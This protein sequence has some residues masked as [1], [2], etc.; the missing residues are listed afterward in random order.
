MLSTLTILQVMVLSIVFATAP[1][2]GAVIEMISYG[3]ISMVDAV[4]KSGDS[5]N[6]TLLVKDII[7]VA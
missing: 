4:R 3:P 7:P 1:L 5:M 2:D 6:N